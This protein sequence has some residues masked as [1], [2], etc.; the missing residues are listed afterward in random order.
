MGILHEFTCTGCH[1]RAELSG[2][3]DVGMACMTTTILCEDCHELYDVVISEKPWEG[4]EKA[5][6]PSC[7][8]HESHTVR[9]WTDPGPCPRC[10]ETM[11]RGGKTVMW[12]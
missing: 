4:A 8:E 7:P 1:H 5:R 2:G 12:D 11:E 6:E 9:R 3:D 10:G